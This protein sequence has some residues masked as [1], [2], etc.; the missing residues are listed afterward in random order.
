MVHSRTIYCFRSFKWC[1]S[2]GQMEQS[3]ENLQSFIII[4]IPIREKV[5]S[6]QHLVSTLMSLDIWSRVD[7]EKWIYSDAGWG[8]LPSE[9]SCSQFEGAPGSGPAPRWAVSAE[10]WTGVRTAFHDLW[11]IHLLQHFLEKK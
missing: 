4:F 8:C 6:Q 5:F 11:L 10:A 1:L 3:S 7:S 2:T 9:N